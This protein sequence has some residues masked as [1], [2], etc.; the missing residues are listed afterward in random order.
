MS[1]LLGQR[2]ALAVELLGRKLA[3]IATSALGRDAEDDEDGAQAP[4]YLLRHSSLDLLYALI[5]YIRM[6]FTEP[7][8][9]L[10]T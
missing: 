3:D 2:V 1:E 4:G 10:T 8:L 6:Q 7:P 5:Q 9:S